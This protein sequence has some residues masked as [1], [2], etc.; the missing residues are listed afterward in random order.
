MGLA[1]DSQKVAHSLNPA[2]LFSLQTLP[3]Y[4]AFETETKIGFNLWPAHD[5]NATDA[6]I[7]ATTD[8]GCQPNIL[9]WLKSSC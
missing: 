7:Q 1:K 3:C 4:E 5:L 6:E 9:V 2:L 8:G